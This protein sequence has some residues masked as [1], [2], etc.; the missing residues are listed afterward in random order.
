VV[1]CGGFIDRCAVA[2]LAGFGLILLRI[3]LHLFMG[4]YQSAY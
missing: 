4:D 3:L 2:I 1:N